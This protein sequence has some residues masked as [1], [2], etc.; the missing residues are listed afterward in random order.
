LSWGPRCRLLL[1][2]WLLLAWALV[3]VA[4]GS[5]CCRLEA[6]PLRGIAGG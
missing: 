4:A 3:V 2:G 6:F 5:C 1:Q